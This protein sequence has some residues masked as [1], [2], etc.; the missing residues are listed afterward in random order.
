[1]SNRILLADDSITIQKVVNLTFADE[2][3]EVVAVSNGDQAE[4]RLGEI[5]PDLVLADIFMPG[6][7][8]YELCELI[9]QNPQFQNVPVV[10]LVGAFEPF[11]QGEAKRVKADA[12]LTKPF[13]SRTLVE[14][15]RKL[16]SASGR[17]PTA[18]TGSL[19]QPEPKIPTAPLETRPLAA[20]PPINIDLG[21]MSNQW[22][23]EEASQSAQSGAPTGFDFSAV[24]LPS[25]PPP[26]EIDVQPEAPTQLGGQTLEF[27]SPF[28][29]SPRVD[30]VVS[31]DELNLTLNEPARSVPV[32]VA[33][34]SEQAAAVPHPEVGKASAFG[35]STPD[36]VIDFEKVGDASSSAPENVVSFDAEKSEAMV[37]ETQDIDEYD[38]GKLEPEPPK[39]ASEPFAAAEPHALFEAP[40]V[41]SPSVTTSLLT[42]ESPLGDILMVEQD[43]SEPT[44]EVIEAVPTDAGDFDASPQWTAIE[45]ISAQLSQAAEEAGRVEEHR[46][47]ADFSVPAPPATDV[48]PP[49]VMGLHPPMDF[50]ILPVEKPETPAALRKP[51]YETEG[52]VEAGF[53]FAENTSEQPTVEQYGSFT[54]AAMWS[55][56]QSP[57][58]SLPAQEPP[59]IE[60][61]TGFDFASHSTPTSE[62]FEA[63]VSE[64]VYAAPQPEKASEQE[65]QVV[66]IPQTLIDEIVRRV[67]AQLSETVVREIAWEVVPDCVER[68]VKEMTRADMS[69]RF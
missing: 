54:S 53:E 57:V 50:E 19:P 22:P 3:I 63:S 20:A 26:I 39:F 2:G 29:F 60:A 69:K 17:P 68:I 4:R 52:L 35:Y 12:H 28:A 13:E 6:K 48:D 25:G 7:N 24:T 27:G 5:N 15:V 36:I 47:E 62:S 49:A 42:S 9:K 67:V 46:V 38:T 16:I 61:D 37:S 21:A 34:A 8:G 59:E 66:E 31:Q 32:Q 56:Q 55:T 18:T 40:A 44:V 11:D 58:E 30:E 10:L 1:M 65:M 45:D 14:T 41:E 33:E 51:D 23:S 43:Y 64:P